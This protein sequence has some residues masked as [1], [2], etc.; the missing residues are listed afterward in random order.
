MVHGL[1]VCPEL[2]RETHGV[3]V[4]VVPPSYV[5]EMSRISNM[6]VMIA[7]FKSNV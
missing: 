2:R 4:C 1:A 7:Y 3:S 5:L 6:W